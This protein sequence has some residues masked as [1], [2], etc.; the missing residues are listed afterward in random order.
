MFN[1]RLCQ[2]VILAIVA[3][4]SAQPAKDP[5]T[6]S[7]SN[8]GP[9]VQCHSVAVVGSMIGKTVCT[10]KADRDAQQADMNDLRDAVRAQDSGACRQKNCGGGQ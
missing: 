3:G 7:A 9:D 4:C 10:T 2:L 8:A 1:A 5:G 6:K